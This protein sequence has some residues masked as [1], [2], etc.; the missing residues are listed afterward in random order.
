[1]KAPIMHSVG[2][3]QNYV[4]GNNMNLEWSSYQKA[5]LASG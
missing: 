1:M 4:Q 2:K 3:M 5:N